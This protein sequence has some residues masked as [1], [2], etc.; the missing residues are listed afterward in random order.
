VNLLWKG[1]IYHFH[2]FIIVLNKDNLI[3]CLNSLLTVHSSICDWSLCLI[4]NKCK[5][6]ITMILLGGMAIS[7]FRYSRKYTFHSWRRLRG[8]SYWMS[9]SICKIINLRMQPS[10][11]LLREQIILIWKY[12][13]FYSIWNK[14][15]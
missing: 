1:S 6:R 12:N 10:K 4:Q 14:K 9:T 5:S 15:N 13:L 11:V 7:L 3:N 8:V 2:L